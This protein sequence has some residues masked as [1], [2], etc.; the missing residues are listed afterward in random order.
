MKDLRNGFIKI[1]FSSNPN[2]RE[3]TLQSEQ[4][5]TELIEAWQADKSKETELHTLYDKFR[6]RGEWFALEE[7]DIEDIYQ[8]FRKHRKLSDGE[9]DYVAFL[10]D[11]NKRLQSEVERLTKQVED[12]DAELSAFK[13]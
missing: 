9:S 13:K 12:L 11:Q 3:K 1:G 10:E 7:T 6:V 5:K 4:P 8:F 2:R